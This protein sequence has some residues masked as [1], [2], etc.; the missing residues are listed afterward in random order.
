M[1]NSEENTI[2]EDSNKPSSMIETTKSSVNEEKISRTLDIIQSSSVR[3]K[4]VYK[5]LTYIRTKVVECQDGIKVLQKSSGLKCLLKV[6]SHNNEDIINITLSIL[7]NL[8]GHLIMN[9]EFR[10][11]VRPTVHLFYVLYLTLYLYCP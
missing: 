9:E 11:E 1:E 4:E 6:L 2:N 10:E 8:C 3:T 7:G 5:A